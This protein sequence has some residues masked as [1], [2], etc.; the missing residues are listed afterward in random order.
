M[1]HAWCHD[2]ARDA[3]VRAAEDG[4]DRPLPTLGG[5]IVRAF[6]FNKASA[7]RACDEVNSWPEDVQKDCRFVL[8]NLL[9][10]GVERLQALVE[11]WR[12]GKGLIGARYPDMIPKSVSASSAPEHENKGDGMATKSESQAADYRAE[13]T[14]QPAPEATRI[15]R[16]TLEC[17]HRFA[18]PPAQWDWW[19]L[20]ELRPGES[21][22]V[23]EDEERQNEMSNMEDTLKDQRDA[24]IRERDELNARVAELQAASGGGEGEAV[25]LLREVYVQAGNEASPNR[26]HA[27]TPRLRDD[28]RDFLQCQPAVPASGGGEGEPVNQKP[29]FYAYENCVGIVA[30]SKHHFGEVAGC[31]AVPLYRQPPQPRGWLS[32]EER[33]A[34]IFLIGGGRSQWLPRTTYEAKRNAAIDACRQL[35]ARSSPPEV[36]LPENPYH[37]S[38]LR[39]GF[40]HALRSVRN[41]LVNAGVEVK[42]APK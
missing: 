16:V 11:A 39:E 35:I 42:D 32:E 9:E 21:V 22:R 8:G 27:L 37:P 26:R 33:E 38:G 6:G 34:V 12:Y 14:A 25:R 7:Q 15:D 23:V 13:A 31:E 19:R 2:I 30:F 1:N 10:Q 24:A 29:G 41:E 18:K 5:A 40:E 28:I 4:R 36:V 17:V 20:M 3:A